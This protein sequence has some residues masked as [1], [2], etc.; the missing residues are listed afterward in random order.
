MD[1]RNIENIAPVV[2]TSDPPPSI[3]NFMS[4]FE[5][6][7]KFSMKE[8]L[9]SLA[10]QLFLNKLA[11][12]YQILMKTALPES[13]NVNVFFFERCFCTRTRAYINARLKRYTHNQVKIFGIFTN[14][15]SL[16]T[17]VSLFFRLRC[18]GCLN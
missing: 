6:E 11:K 8:K 7:K 4:L 2:P 3:R 10:Q 12:F 1:Q 16:I 14:K 9:Y 5:Q 17:L 18:K 13:I 15:E